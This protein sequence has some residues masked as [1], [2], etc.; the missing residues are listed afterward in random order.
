MHYTESADIKDKTTHNNYIEKIFYFQKI[1]KV[2]LYEQNMKSLRIYDAL[3]MNFLQEIACP[4]VILDVEHAPDKNAIA[5]SLS[6]RTIVF[7]DCSKDTS[8]IKSRLHVPSTQ[9]CLA[10]VRR[11]RKSNLF[12]AGVDGSI[13]AW[14]LEK[15]FNNKNDD[16]SNQYGLNQKT[17]SAE[18]QKDKEKKEYVQFLAE[19]TPWYVDDIILC[20]VDLPN[21]NQLA[22]GAYNR[23]ICLWDLRSNSVVDK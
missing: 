5:V 20:L 16:D 13:F 3:T 19:K 11:S 10:Y 18:A 9:K 23:L 6:D 17:L 14:N 4:G 12:S 1:D 2:Y 7:F 8:K 22:S 21:I 15:V